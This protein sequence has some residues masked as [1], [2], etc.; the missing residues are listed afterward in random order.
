LDPS[1]VRG[2]EYY[3]GPVYELEL[4]FETHDEEGR[5]VR[6]GSV[7]G[8]GRYDELVARFRAEPVPATG[9]SIGVSRLMAALAYLR[10]SENRHRSGPVLVTVFDRDRIIDYQ[11]MVQE[12]RNANIAA[13]LYLGAGKMGQQLKYADKRGSPCVVIQGSNERAEGKIQ[14]KDLMIGAGVARMAQNRGD[15]LRKQ[16]KAQFT[17]PETELVARVRKLLARQARS[18]EPSKRQLEAL[19]YQR[20]CAAEWREA[21]AAGTLEAGITWSK[22]YAARCKQLKAR[23]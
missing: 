20:T 8:G 2:L 23:V 10:E 5:P 4:T 14:I 18:K 16:T 17:V 3:T 19:K 13:E 6:F 11:R 22:F 12:L 1:V 7:G 15:Y 9:I 21:K